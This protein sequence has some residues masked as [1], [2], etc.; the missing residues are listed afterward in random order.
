MTEF[1]EGTVSCWCLGSIW[2][3]NRSSAPVPSLL[4]LPAHRAGLIPGIFRSWLFHSPLPHAHIGCSALSGYW[5]WNVVSDHLLLQVG[6]KKYTVQLSLWADV[7]NRPWCRVM[8]TDLNGN[9]VS[10]VSPW[11]L[12]S[13]YFDLISGDHFSCSNVTSVH[14]FEHSPWFGE[15]LCI[16]SSYWYYSYNRFKLLRYC[17]N[18]FWP[19]GDRSTCH[20]KRG[21][22]VLMWNVWRLALR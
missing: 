11:C 6:C 10:E 2:E 14:N 3:R 16:Y 19:R 4:L 7:L 9:S 20:L 13:F 21:A 12:I 17:W 15:L 8:F 22:I 1:I 18:G 5:R